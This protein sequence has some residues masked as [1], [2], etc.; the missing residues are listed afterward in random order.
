MNT[1]ENG[2]T[3]INVWVFFVTSSPF[4]SCAS[5]KYGPANEHFQNCKASSSSFLFKYKIHDYPDHT[6]HN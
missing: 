1:E 6:T 5:M 2:N 3:A 4:L